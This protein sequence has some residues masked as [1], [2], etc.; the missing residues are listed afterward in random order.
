MTSS[1]LIGS[2][3]VAEALGVSRPTITR[4]AQ[5]GK[6]KPAHRG[7]GLRGALVFRKSEVERVKR[8]LPKKTAA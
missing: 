1:N 2:V 7:A 4:W 8:Q 6:I 3:E 5:T